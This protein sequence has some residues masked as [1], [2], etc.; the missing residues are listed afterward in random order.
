[1]Y[2]QYRGWKEITL[3]VKVLPVSQKTKS[4]S[5]KRLSLPGD[6]SDEESLP[7]TKTPKSDSAQKCGSNYR[8]HLKKITE[9]DSIVK[10]LETKKYSPEQIRV[11]AHMLQ[12]NKHDSYDSPPTKPFFKS[13]KHVQESTQADISPGK[14]L[15]MRSEV[16]VYLPTR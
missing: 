13:A 10:E 1:M 3:W 12:M 9:V 16:R 2:Q 4:S 5:R 15:N 6:G 7:P 11:W 8:N 14:R